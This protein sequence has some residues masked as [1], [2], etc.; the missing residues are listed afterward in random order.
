VARRKKRVKRGTT[1]G[2]ARMPAPVGRPDRQA[3]HQV[4]LPARRVRVLVCKDGTALL[5]KCREVGTM[6]SGDYMIHVSY[7]P[8]YKVFP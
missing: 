2:M 1:L 8:A 6:K 3:V 4:E 7:N 5:R